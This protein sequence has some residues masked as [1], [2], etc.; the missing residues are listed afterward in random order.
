M[1][2]K[3]WLVLLVPVVAM[4]AVACTAP[5]PGEAVDPGLAGSLVLPLISLLAALL[6]LG[7][8]YGSSVCVFIFCQGF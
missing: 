6:T 4:V 2:K 1:K 5:P 3:F 8:G 7:Q